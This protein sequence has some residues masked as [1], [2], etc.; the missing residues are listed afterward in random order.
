MSDDRPALNKL[1]DRAKELASELL[2]AL[3]GLFQPPPQ[4]VPIPVPIPARRP[5]ARRYTGSN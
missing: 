1:S 2:E 3:D 5:R 4:L